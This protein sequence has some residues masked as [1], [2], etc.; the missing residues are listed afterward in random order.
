VE[1]EVRRM[2]RVGIVGREE[3]VRERVY[4]ISVEKRL[5]NPAVVAISQ[6]ARR[7]LGQA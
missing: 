5:K 4:A 3:S 2:Y 1:D 6:A 7:T